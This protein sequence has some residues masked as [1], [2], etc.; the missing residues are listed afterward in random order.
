MRD[1]LCMHYRMHHHRT[2]QVTIIN[3]RLMFQEI[4]EFIAQSSFPMFLLR[5]NIF[6]ELLIVSLNC[7]Q[8]RDTHTYA[9]ARALHTFAIPLT[10]QELT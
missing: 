4:H 9:R 8:Y 7:Q 10:P 5:C 6:P 1:T 2:Q 3:Y